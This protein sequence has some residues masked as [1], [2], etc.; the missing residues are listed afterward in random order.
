LSELKFKK[1]LIIGLGLIG[2]SF[3]KAIKKHN[4]S[5][6]IFAYDLDSETIDF[7]AANNLIKSGSTNLNLL[8]EVFDLIVIAS[9][10]SSY[11]EILYQ[12]EDIA[13]PQTL[14]MDLGSLKGFIG[15]ILPP[16]LVKNFIGCHPIAGSEKNGLENSTS[17][18]FENKKTII[19]PHHQHDKTQLKKAE[20]IFKT[21]GCST[22]I[23]DPKKHDEIYALVSHLPQF[24]S[25][26]TKEFSPKNIK[27]EFLKKVFRLDDSSPEIWSDIFEINEENLENLY[28]EFFDNLEKNITHISNL[29]NF[30]NNNSYQV[31]D[32]KFFEENFA[33]IFFRAI[34]VKSYLEIA[35]IKTHQNYGGT[36]FRD[37]TSAIEIFNFDQE[38]L[39][40]LIAENKSKIVKIF[41]SLA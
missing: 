32:K 16:K 15:E 27:D 28:L 7:A 25:F 19:C 6:E 12:L 35:E 13:S 36:G 1:T 23:I 33:A 29:N 40:N 41:K 20:E 39:T 37:F 31:Q 10:L 9:P 17:D 14:L 34:T 11:E 22:E 5:N 18:L 38:K 4:L 24:L 30:K 8:D 3:A 26:L 21:I 2:G